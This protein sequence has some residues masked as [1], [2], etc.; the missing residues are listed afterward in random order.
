MDHVTKTVDS[1]CNGFISSSEKLR[2]F[3]D[4]YRQATNM[5][6][7]V[8]TSRSYIKMRASSSS[9]S[10]GNKYGVGGVKNKSQV[11]EKRDFNI[12]TTLIGT[13]AED[14][15]KDQQHKLLS[16]TTADVEVI[17]KQTKT[18]LSGNDT[19][20]DITDNKNHPIENQQLQQQQYKSEKITLMD[21]IMTGIYFIVNGVGRKK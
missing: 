5:L 16:S 8:R 10:S 6:F 21:S 19:G 20:S 12:E 9:S 15:V 3:L 13:K 11:M 14:T 7:T 18:S 1:Y 2:Q 17:D 4:E